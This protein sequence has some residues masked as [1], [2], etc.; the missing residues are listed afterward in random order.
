MPL[1]VWGQLRFR[2][3]E[4]ALSEI[5]LPMKLEPRAFGY[6]RGLRGVTIRETCTKL[7]TGAFSHCAG[8]AR[9]RIPE[10]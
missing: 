10:M 9:V 6:Y 2:F 5:A 7:G 3:H 1:L 8:I 4:T